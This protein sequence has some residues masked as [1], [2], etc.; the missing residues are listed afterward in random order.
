MS[1]ETM[2][3]P[4]LLFKYK[5]FSAED[6][7]RWLCDDLRKGRIYGAC[8][9]EL[10]DPFEGTIA[11]VE[12]AHAGSSFASILDGRTFANAEFANKVRIVSLTENPLSSLMWA[13]YG[14]DYQGVCLCF[15]NERPFCN[16]K[17]VTYVTN[18]HM[19]DCNE[20]EYH[21]KDFREHAIDLMRRGLT[22]KHIDWQ[23]EKEWRLLLNKTREE[24]EYVAYPKRL[25]KGIVFGHKMHQE[26]INRIKKHVPSGVQFLKTKP[27]EHS[28]FINLLPE[29]YEVDY[30]GETPPFIKDM[31]ELEKV[32]ANE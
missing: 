19:L 30:T 15:K 29:E 2:N 24:A 17:S 12:T 16:A 4:K 31:N 11:R 21:G 3:R 5:R 23:Y 8:I 28:G 6:N 22:V 13:H 10:N 1:D 14:D 20:R 25:L 27:G 32:L 7:K 18:T 9:D 26:D